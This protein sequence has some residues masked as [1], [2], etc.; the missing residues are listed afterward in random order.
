MAESA[1]Q[2]SLAK[3]LFRVLYIHTACEETTER[4]V[5]VRNEQDRQLLKWLI[6]TP[7]EVT[8]VNTAHE[9]A[10]G[11]AKPYLSVVCRRLGPSVPRFSTPCPQPGKIGEQHLQAINHILQRPCPSSLRRG[12]PGPTKQ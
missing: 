2:L 5:R 11:D 9:C 1:Y 7:G 10:R 12:W 3:L 8:I 6:E 4:W